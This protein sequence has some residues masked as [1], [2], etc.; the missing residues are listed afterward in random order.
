MDI[1]FVI[2]A[3]SPSA[4]LNFAK[5]KDIVREVIDLYGVQRVYYSVILFGR[6]PT[7]R[8]RFSQQYPESALKATIAAL[9]RPTDGSSLHSALESAQGVFSE[10]GRPDAKKVVVVVVDEKSESSI[11]D[12]KNAAG[13]LEDDG[14]KVI[15]VAFG[16]QASH[17]ETSAATVNKDNIV[18]ANRTDDPKDIAEEI[19]TKIAKGENLTQTYKI[20]TFQNLIAR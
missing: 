19:T 10:G 9:P 3:T 2:S 1:A 20:K 17:D 5:I 14:I 8:I 4:I 15:A 7:V 12:V 13:M 6:D 16:D 11:E 18:K